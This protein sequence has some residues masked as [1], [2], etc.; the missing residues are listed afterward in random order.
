MERVLKCLLSQ[1]PEGWV[2]PCVSGRLSSITIGLTL[3]WAVKPRGWR[4]FRWRVWKLGNGE[5]TILDSGVGV[6][7]LGVRSKY[8]ERMED[9]KNI[10]VEPKWPLFSK[11]DRHHFMGQVFQNMGYWGAKLISECDGNLVL[12]SWKHRKHVFFFCGH[13]QHHVEE[14]GDI[15]I[16]KAFSRDSSIAWDHCPFWAFFGGSNTTNLGFPTNSANDNPW[17]SPAD[18]WSNGDDIIMFQNL[19]T[20]FQ[21]QRDLE[22]SGANHQGET[23]MVSVID[24][25]EKKQEP[26]WGPPLLAHV[27]EKK[28]HNLWPSF[29]VL[30][31][32]ILE[33]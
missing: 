10:P 14:N 27:L 11:V 21:S 26:G 16:V 6:G 22:I 23:S 9:L 4:K 19:R 17:F 8:N 33:F 20:F 2:H 7:F 5:L 12:R 32:S 18:G 25:P 29:T 31:L 30:V 24:F 3:R 15:W 1:A 13:P 28:G